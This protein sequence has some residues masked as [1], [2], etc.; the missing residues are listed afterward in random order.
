[1][2]MAI[3]TNADLSRECNVSVGVL[4]IILTIVIVIWL[5]TKVT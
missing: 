1:M 4:W 3:V 2:A 5:V